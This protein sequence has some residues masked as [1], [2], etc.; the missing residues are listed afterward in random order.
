MDWDLHVAYFHGTSH[1]DSQILT[2]FFVNN[3]VYVF[4]RLSQG[5]LSSPR[6]YEVLNNLVYEDTILPL[7]IESAHN[8]LDFPPPSKWE[9]IL[10]CFQDDSWC[11]SPMNYDHHLY[12]LAI[13]LYALARSGLKLSPKKCV[14]ASTT[15]YIIV[16]CWKLKIHSCSLSRSGD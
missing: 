12:I 7:A 10:K 8:P 13:Q 9:E 5:L 11:H 16:S 15:Y 2:A 14:I 3:A 1:A 4:R 6:A